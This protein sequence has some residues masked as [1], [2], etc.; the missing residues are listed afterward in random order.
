MNVKLAALMLSLVAV[1]PLAAQDWEAG[2]FL[3]QQTHGN[4]SVTDS[5]GTTTAS[6]PNKTVVGLRVGHA[7]LDFGPVLL[8]GTAGYQPQTTMTLRESFSAGGAPRSTDYK[9]G[10]ASLGAML[11]L[12]AFFALGAG[13]EYRFEK[14][15]TSADSTTYARPWLRLN[16][17]VAIPSPVVKPFLGVEAS[18]PLTNKK[19]DDA[20]STADF[21]K[22]LAPKAQVGLYA[23][24]RF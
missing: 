9:T 21:L 20:V 18:F 11:N 13:L 17:G 16:A 19:I 22:V 24:V 8:Q 3:G 1:A 10:Y 6:F 5:V 12:K 14:I 23:G 7:I 2:A 15:E 4:F